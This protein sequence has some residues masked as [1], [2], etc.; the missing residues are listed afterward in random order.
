M[1]P[2][3]LSRSNN[4]LMSQGRHGEGTHNVAEDYY[5]TPAWDVRSPVLIIFEKVLTEA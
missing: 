5:G 4:N 3:G 1:K 2:C